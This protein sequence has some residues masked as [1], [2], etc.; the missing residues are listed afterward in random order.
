MRYAAVVVEVGG[1]HKCLPLDN[2]VSPTIHAVRL[3]SEFKLDS[4][5]REI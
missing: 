1:T 4:I 2:D 3:L 5:F